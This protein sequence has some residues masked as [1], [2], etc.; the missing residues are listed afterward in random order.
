[1]P[2]YKR[3]LMVEV[4][5]N[6]MDTEANLGRSS[7]SLDSYWSLDE[8][9]DTKEERVD[10]LLRDIA[11]ES[12]DPVAR[13]RAKQAILERLSKEELEELAEAYLRKDHQANRRSSES[14]QRV[15]GIAEAHRRKTHQ[16]AGKSAE[17]PAPDFEPKPLRPET[18]NVE[19]AAVLL[20]IGRTLAYDQARCGTLPGVRKMGGRYKVSKTALHAYLALGGDGVLA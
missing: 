9:M 16:S 13:K 12:P 19:E 3:N 4:S 7:E 20:G 18:Y 11:R 8:V 5:E 2:N 17:A 10:Q 6:A 14:N 1:M 15:I